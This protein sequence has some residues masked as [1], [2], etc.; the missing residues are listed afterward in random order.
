MN[1]QNRR[2]YI[3]AMAWNAKVAELAFAVRE[4]YDEMTW[5]DS[6][7]EEGEATQAQVDAAKIRHGEAVSEL[8]AFARTGR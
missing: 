7:M 1:L 2:E 6:M 4:T 8:V 3:E 5:K